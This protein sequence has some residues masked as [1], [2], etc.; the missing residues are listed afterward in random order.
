MPDTVLPVDRSK[1]TFEQAEGIEPLPTQLQSREISKE[2]QA[3]LWNY[4]WQRLNKDL[5]QMEYGPD[6][7]RGNWRRVLTDM[8]VFRD[9]GMADEFEDHFDKM[10]SH[11]KGIVT[12]GDYIKVF[13]FL[14]WVMRH[15]NAPFEFSEAIDRILIRC[16]AAYRVVGGQTI[17]P[18]GSDQER[19]AIERALASTGIPEFRGARSHLQQAASDLS[20]GQFADSVRNS[21]HAVEGIA[22]VLAPSDKLSD[23]LSQLEA[24]IGMHPAMKRGFAA[25]YGWTS[26]EQGIRHPL[27]DAGDAKVSEADALFMLGACAAFVS[28]LISNGRKSQLL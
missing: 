10:A 8:H 13:G 22:R 12:S 9:G 6:R 15:R 27:L 23:A 14:Q 7:I 11:V 17:I 18:L 24:A 21:I 5:E 2:L 16:R 4:V 26:D 19:D 25:L 28:F 3:H 20:A 1:V